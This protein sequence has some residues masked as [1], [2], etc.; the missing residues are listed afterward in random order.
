MDVAISVSSS[1][2]E[3]K[4]ASPRIS[5][6]ELIRRGF[7]VGRNI[8]A[9]MANSLILAYIGGSLLLVM[10]YLVGEFPF[11]QIINTEFIALEITRGLIGSLGFVFVIPV[12]AIIS[13]MWLSRTTGYKT[14]TVR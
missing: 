2:Q 3:I 8:M 10:V 6:G 9:T 11:L 13:G 12:T 14:K 4:G 5:Q 1:I 7:N